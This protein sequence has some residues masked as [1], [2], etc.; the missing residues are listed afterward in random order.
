LPDA[1]RSAIVFG[2]IPPNGATGEAF[3]DDFD[4]DYSEFHQLWLDFLDLEPGNLFGYDKDVPFTQLQTLVF[5]ASPKTFTRETSDAQPQEY[6][7]VIPTR[8]SSDPEEWFNDENQFSVELLRKVYDPRN[9]DDPSGAYSY[10]IDRLDNDLSNDGITNIFREQMSKML[11]DECRPYMPQGAIYT[12]NQK[13]WNG[14]RLKEDDFFVTW[15]RAGRAWGWDINRNGYYDMNEVNPRYV[16]SHIPPDDRHTL[17]PVRAKG[18]APAAE[19]LEEELEEPPSTDKEEMRGSTFKIDSDPD[20]DPAAED[21]TEQIPWMTRS[22]LAPLAT[23][24]GGN[25]GLEFEAIRAKPVN[26]TTASALKDVTNEDGTRAVDY[27][28][29]FPVKTLGGLRTGVNE[30]GWPSQPA[31]SYQW[32]MMDKGQAPKLSASSDVWIERNEWAYPLQM[33]QKD[34][35]FDQVGEVANAF[36]W[37]HALQHRPGVTTPGNIY[38]NQRFLPTIATFGE[39]MNGSKVDDLF[40]V[41]KAD[42]PS[43]GEPVPSRI[44]TNRWYAD[45]G[46]LEGIFAGVGNNA[47]RPYTQVLEVK[48]VDNSW[49]PILPAGVGFF[50]SLVCDGPGSNYRPRTGQ[51]DNLD[52]PLAGYLGYQDDS[53]GNA[54]AFS[55]NPTRGLININT[56]S[57]EVLRTLPHM[58][59]LVYND[60]RAWQGTEFAGGSWLDYFPANPVRGDVDESGIKPIS[61][62]NN[63][64]VRVPEMMIRYR[65]GESMIKRV[66]Q[67]RYATGGGGIGQSV[68]NA[69][70]PV[71]TDRGTFNIDSV[72]VVPDDWVTSNITYPVDPGGLVGFFPGMRRDKGIVSIGELML[73]EKSGAFDS[74]GW[75]GQ[76]TSIRAAGSDPYYYQS[77]LANIY[78]AE[79]PSGYGVDRSLLGIGWR[80]SGLNVSPVQADA[81]LSTDVQHTTFLAGNVV[82]VPDNVASDAEESNMLFAGMSNLISTRSDTFTV[83][84]KIRSFKQNPVSGV[85]NAMDPE[86][87]VDDS[88]YVMVVD[89]SKCELPTDEP[90]IRLRAQVPN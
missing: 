4:L 66:E 17:Y 52:D 18:T 39:I 56:A 63:H 41:V 75:S 40:P 47:F 1:P 33:L 84:I 12:N 54:A 30:G 19:G 78:G 76:A 6:S 44:H 38:N 10:V 55:G 53:F 29:G 81:R 77:P 67:G 60:S 64:W 3:N 46:N 35:D 83:Y 73:L 32:I 62:R 22:Y 16:Y 88:R 24:P 28:A 86:Y 23:K 61:E 58:S 9:A 74:G 5:D 37:G 13:L 8:L 11:D 57:P 2:I 26:F 50:D 34:S 59:R 85:W 87:I 69:A 21:I 90:E 51:D 80:S 72:N 48:G 25:G 14:I 20:G 89:R 27:D 45:P 79:M 7:P 70:L 82:Q 31:D 71:Y 68:G 65:N 15:T 43:N 49:T 42:L 36:L